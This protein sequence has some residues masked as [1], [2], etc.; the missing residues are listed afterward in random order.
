MTLFKLLK[1]KNYWYSKYLNAN[2]AFLQALLHAPEVALDE[3]ELFYGNRESLL[4]II[5]NVDQNIQIELEGADW[6][7]KTPTSADKTLIQQY[8]RDK[9]SIIKKIVELDGQILVRM[10]EL[11]LE[12]ME[13][14]RAL[15]KGKKALSGYRANANNNDKLN[16][17]V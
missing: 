6:K 12:G 9:D 11:K 5:E 14:I 16:K 15:S 8:I 17:R 4:K 2:E 1:D 10:E 13:K 7:A 3:L